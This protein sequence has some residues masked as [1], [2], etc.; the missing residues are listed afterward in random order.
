MIEYSHYKNT[1]SNE[2]KHVSCNHFNDGFF[3]YR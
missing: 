3:W 2:V 1:I